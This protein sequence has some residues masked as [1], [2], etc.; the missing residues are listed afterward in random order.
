MLPTYKSGD[1]VLTFNWF[2]FGASDV[3]VFE[4]LTKKYIKRVTKIIND[5]VY[6]AGDNYSKSAVI[7][8]IK[9]ADVVGKVIW[10]Y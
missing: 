7:G 4:L 1:R 3:V 2:D 6:V 8:P 10:K 5:L 9:K